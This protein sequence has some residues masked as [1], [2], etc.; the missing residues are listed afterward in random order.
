MRATISLA[1]VLTLVGACSSGPQT[2]YAPVN[3]AYVASEGAEPISVA[4]ARKM[5]YEV[6]NE[7]GETLYCQEAKKTGSRI[8]K[9]TTCLT[10]KEIEIARDAAQRNVDN[11][12]RPVPPPHG[13]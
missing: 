4:E 5:G 13:T 3:H 10:R 1:A 2:V 9:E 8:R 7:N 6:V 11:L 12:K